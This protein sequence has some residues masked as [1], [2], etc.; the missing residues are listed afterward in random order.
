MRA[1]L[2]IIGAGIIGAAIA[3]EAANAGLHVQVLTQN[4]PGTGVTATGMGHIVVLDDEPSE[5]ALCKLSSELWDGFAQ[6]TEAEYRRCGTLWVACNAKENALLEEKRIRLLAAGINATSIDSRDIPRF[7]PNLRSGLAGALLVERDAVVYAPRM[8]AYLLSAPCQTGCIDVRMAHVT[9]IS[10]GVVQLYGGEKLV[11]D[12]VVVAAGLASQDLLPEL[13]L[14]PRKGH[15]VITDRYPGWVNHQVLEVGYSAS[16]HG[17]GESVAFNIQPRATGQLLLGSS[18]QPQVSTREVDPGVLA[19]MIARAQEFMPKLSSLRAIRAWTGVRPGTPDG[20]PY[21]GR[22]PLVSN[23]WL[24]AGHEGLGITTALGTARLLIDQIL[25]RPLSVD[26]SP[27]S[28]LR[29][30]QAARAEHIA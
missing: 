17:S 28:P 20:K 9:G 18:R 11:A 6:T 12:A 4:E 24:A 26:P 15:L 16:A 5:L 7:E 2:I 25:Q 14:V 21:I 3:R 22:W 23:C 1:D 30:F 13:T 27:Y 10:R 8:A 29:Q 19:K